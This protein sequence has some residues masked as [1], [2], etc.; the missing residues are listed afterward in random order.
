MPLP[1][2]LCAARGHPAP[3][4]TQVLAPQATWLLLLAGTAEDEAAVDG[5]QPA[6]PVG[7]TRGVRV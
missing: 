1:V 4:V 2:R 6:A 7:K 5:Q 3:V